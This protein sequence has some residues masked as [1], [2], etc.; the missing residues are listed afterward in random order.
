MRSQLSR[1]A[2]RA[3]RAIDPSSVARYAAEMGVRH[4]EPLLFGM[5]GML[6][7]AKAYEKR[8]GDKLAS[9][10]V[11]GP[12]YLSVICGLRNLLNGDGAV[13]MEQNVS[14]DS[15]DNGMIESIFWLCMEVAGFTEDAL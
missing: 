14:T 11:L 8:Y 6:R 12:Y 7:Y 13:A 3:L 5:D 15:K 4:A 2:E 9:D 10:Y 1:E